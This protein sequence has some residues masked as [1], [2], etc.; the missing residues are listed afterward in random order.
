MNN[1]NLTNVINQKKILVVDDEESIRSILN[2]M[3]T[4]QGHY[5]IEARNGAEG[6]KKYTKDIDL[7][8]TDMQMP[9]MNG[10]DLVDN[11]KRINE[12]VKIIPVTGSCDENIFKG[13]QKHILG[14]ITKP[15]RLYSEGKPQASSRG[16]QFNS[17]DQALS[18]AF[19]K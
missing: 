16:L 6:L 19:P 1:Q 15:F 14:Y 7:V 8:I 2:S 5:V 18:Y 17:L 13:I 3:L 12:N 9:E 4:M 11:L 10:F